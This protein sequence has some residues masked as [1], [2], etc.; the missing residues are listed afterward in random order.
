MTK[1]K[2]AFSAL[3]AAAFIVS[4]LGWSAPARAYE[5]PAVSDHACTSDI[6][7]PGTMS[8]VISNAMVLGLNAPSRNV[9]RFLDGAHTRY[10]TGA[11][12]LTATAKHFEMD[13]AVLAAAVEKFRH[14]NCRLGPMPDGT[15][16]P[17]L[18]NHKCS[19][20]LTRAGDMQDVVSNVLLWELDLPDPKV[21]GFI[22]GAQGRYS[23]GAALLTAAAKHFQVDEAVLAAEVERYKH[24]TCTMAEMVGGELLGH[25]GGVAAGVGDAWVETPIEVS[26]F[27]KDVTLHVV[28]HELGHALIR[29]FDI[30]ILSNEE[31]MADAFA[32]YYLT[33]YMPDRA[34][35]VL[36]ARVTSLMIE[37]REAPGDDWTGE[38]DHDGRRAF[39]I[40]AL[41]VAAGAEKYGPVA[42]V[43]EMSAE[44]ISDAKDYGA[45]IRRSWRRVLGPLWMP[46]GVASSEAK[47][48]YDP[49]DEFINRVCSEGLASEIESAVGRFDWHSQVTVRF[50]DGDGGAGWSRSGRTITVHSEYIRRFVE[51][52]AKGLPAGPN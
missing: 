13:E 10:A 45:E 3:T 37:A 26:A 33:A 16:P 39:Q 42:E 27:A 19:V 52:G 35:D 14:C 5:P 9:Y 22:R 30:P 44:D 24:C 12:V 17:A 43:V 2:S 40:A 4:G 23:S 25:E 20:D 11:E 1:R 8:D 32:T 46:D 31:T 28:L 50:V 7:R 29:E 18:A 51:Q 36:K 21:T 6:A 48:V 34:V 15:P 38:H 41:A 47:V 49:G